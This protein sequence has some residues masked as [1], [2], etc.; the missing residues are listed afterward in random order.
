MAKNIL[1]VEDDHIAA[2]LL[3]TILSKEGFKSKALHSGEEAVEE[4][5]EKEYDIV[6]LD[7]VLP[8][9]SGVDTQ[10]RIRE[11]SPDQLIIFM[12]GRP[13]VESAVEAMK[14][15]AYDY[16]M[17]PYNAQEVLISV[18]RAIET[19]NLRQ[20]VEK[21]KKSA[22]AG[23][24]GEALCHEIYNP[25]SVVHSHIQLLLSALKKGESPD[26]KEYREFFEK[27]LEHINKCVDITNRFRNIYSNVGIE[28]KY[29]NLEETLR[30]IVEGD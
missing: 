10:T 12:T 1:I 24:V 3:K 14:G 22:V 21:M 28:F 16:I 4:V 30:D 26:V 11:V 13:T 25:L 29:G 20:M 23:C 9:L 8:G 27:S 5:K 6:L 19:K 17:K 15:G 2:K 18:N 7:L